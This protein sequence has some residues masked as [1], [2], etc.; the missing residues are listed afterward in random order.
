MER[1]IP[2]SA[3]SNSVLQFPT[4]PKAMSGAEPAHPQVP[5]DDTP[6]WNSPTSVFM[7]TSGRL[8]SSSGSETSEASEETTVQQMEHVALAGPIRACNASKP[9]LNFSPGPAPLPATV[10]EEIQA[11]LLNWRGTG[12]SV[13]CMSHRSPEFGVIYAETV[14]SIKALLRVPSTHEVIFTHGGGHG[15]FAAVPLNLAA[16][17][18]KVD[19]LVSGTWSKRAAAEASKWCS[20]REICPQGDA[21]STGLPP[22]DEWVLD[23]EASYRC[24]NQPPT[25][26]IRFKIRSND[27]TTLRTATPRS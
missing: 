26:M 5:Y 6:S 3:S 21:A 27:E 7:G 11:E 4:P 25:A 2:T 1:T 10:L 19:Y 18:A 8:S 15:Q 24:V 9:L 14:A 16:E 17:G 22:R 13:L 23:P 12:S 20:V